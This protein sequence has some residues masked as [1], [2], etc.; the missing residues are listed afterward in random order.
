MRL[1]THFHPVLRLRIRGAIPTFPHTLSSLVQARLCEFGKDEDVLCLKE[2]SAIEVYGGVEVELHALLPSA[3]SCVS[4]FKN[5]FSNAQIN[6]LLQ[7][8][9]GCCSIACKAAAYGF[10]SPQ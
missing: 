8:C 9:A 3:K 1:T 4:I 2:D 7:N 5:A 10:E 6:C